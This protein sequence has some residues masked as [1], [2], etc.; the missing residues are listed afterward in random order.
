MIILRLLPLIFAQLL[1]AAHIMRSFGS[2]WAILV[3][4]L[5]LT[6]FIRREWIIRIWQVIIAFV[7]LEWIRTTI[8]IVKLRLAIEIPYTRLLIIMC[9]IILFNLFVIYWL[10]RP[11]VKAI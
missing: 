9:A 4:L 1:F 10:Q 2:F 5:L 3:L 7:T 8:I 11:K 6:L